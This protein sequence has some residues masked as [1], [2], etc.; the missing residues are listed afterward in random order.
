LL[1]MKQSCTK[2]MIQKRR[3]IP[4]TSGCWFGLHLWTPDQHA[5]LQAS[6][7]ALAQASQHHATGCLE[8][9]TE[10]AVQR[11]DCICEASHPSLC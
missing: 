10:V 11:H 8:A 1:Q 3:R 7:H 4:H 6:M 2:C 9:G 5:Y